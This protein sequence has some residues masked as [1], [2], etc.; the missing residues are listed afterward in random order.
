MT[1]LFQKILMFSV[2]P[3]ITMITGGMI[4]L[5]KKPSGHLRSL[6]L[7]FAAGVVFSVVAVELLPDVI[8]EHKP[9]QVIVGFALGLITM[10]AIRKFVELAEEKSGSEA[11]GS[12]PMGLLVAIGIDIFIDGL[13]LGIGFSAGGTEG[14]LLAVAL[15][16]ELLSLGMATATELGENKMT[17]PKSLSI[18]AMLALLFF[19]SAVLGGTLLHNLSDSSME[20]VLS[21]G[22]S[23]LL[24]LVTEE[25]L[26]EAH[27]EEESVW[28]TGVFFGGFLL[29]LILGMVV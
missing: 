25:L 27:E 10:L 9:V 18:I 15:S 3:V 21:F 22:L 16:I 28:H 11:G 7:H 20:I 6:I 19:V 29:F 17:K 5:V 13:L 1:P 8:K 2:I 24:F 23:A 12:I 14:M 26:I 4:A